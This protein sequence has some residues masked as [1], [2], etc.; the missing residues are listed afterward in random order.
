MNRGW[1][2]H[3]FR[4]KSTRINWWIARVSTYMRKS[5]NS[6]RAAAKTF[7]KER[8]VECYFTSYVTKIYIDIPKG[9]GKR[10]KQQKKLKNKHILTYG[11]SFEA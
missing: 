9:M 3:Y 2:M 6:T 1:A 7:V 10:Q 11:K 8:K 5:T 4:V